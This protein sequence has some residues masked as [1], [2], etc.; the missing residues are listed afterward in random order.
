MWLTAVRMI[1]TFS[2]TFTESYFCDFWPGNLKLRNSDDVIDLIR[3]YRKLT[4]ENAG[5][6]MSNLKLSDLK[7]SDSEFHIT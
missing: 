4:L 7:M 3:D 6:E 5:L 1:H 2:P